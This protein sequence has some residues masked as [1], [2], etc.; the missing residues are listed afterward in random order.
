MPAIA[1]CIKMIINIKYLLS[2]KFYKIIFK[3]N[4]EIKIMHINIQI[5]IQ[6]F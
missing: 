1:V 4:L 2:E 3:D 5:L 6:N